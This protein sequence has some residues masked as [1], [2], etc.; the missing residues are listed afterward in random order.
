MKT[1]KSFLLKLIFGLLICSQAQASILQ[2]VMPDYYLGQLVRGIL[3]VASKT[4]HPEYEVL[5][6]PAEAAK[7][8]VSVQRIYQYPAHEYTYDD[9]SIVIIRGLDEE[10]NGFSFGNN[11][12]LTKSMIDLLPQNQLTA[13]IA[14][15]LSHSEKAHNLQ[16]TP[17]PLEAAI[18]QLKTIS[19]SLIA[20]RWPQKKDL[21]ESLHAIIDG[22]G[23]AME[24][25]A[26]C[27]A[28]QQLEYMRRRGL[29]NK[30][31][32]LIGATS[33]MLGFDATTDK[34]DDPSAVRTQALLTKSYLH[35]SCDIF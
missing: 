25:Q 15:E 30:P 17:L 14:H 4:G 32:D 11:I 7:A 27:L 35:E 24:L 19:D 5:Y 29:S 28:A 3:G 12:F 33:T 18:Y 13:V 31:E 6:A 2:Y 9:V 16:K 23:L 8:Q 34:S 22:G 20:G 26:D 21:V 10:P 1:K